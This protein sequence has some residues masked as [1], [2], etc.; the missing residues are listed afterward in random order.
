M[1][2]LR[3]QPGAWTPVSTK[4]DAK[5]TR[6]LEKLSERLKSERSERLESGKLGGKAID[7]LGKQLDKSMASMQAHVDNE[8]GAIDSALEAKGEEMQA[9][10]EA[11]VDEAVDKLSTR[12]DSEIGR[13]TEASLSREEL[14]DLLSGIATS[15]R[16]KR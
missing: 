15:L 12:L 5:A 2:K 3:K 10:V 4:F 6:E 11:V 14:A 8:L 13:L 16:K 7:Q 1:H 9:I